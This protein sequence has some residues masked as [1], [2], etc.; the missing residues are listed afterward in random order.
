MKQF[1][2]C[3]TPYIVYL[4]TCPCKKQYIGQ[5]IRNFTTRVKEH[6]T[7][8]KKGKTNHSVP[9]HYA[10]H[11]DRNPAGTTFQVIDRFIPHWRGE[12]NIRGVS[13]LE[14][15]WIYQMKCYVPHGLNIEWDINA[16]INQS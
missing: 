6:I 7:A 10:S 11:H 14:T 15:W 2:T 1:A 12:S 4:I 5:T 8:I 16:F 3:K 13:R 9:K